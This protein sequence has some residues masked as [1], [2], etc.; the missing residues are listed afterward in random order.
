MSK[1]SDWAKKAPVFKVP[2]D[3]IGDLGIVTK[4][5]NLGLIISLSLPNGAPATQVREVIPKNAIAFARWILDT[6]EDK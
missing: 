2:D 3:N 5:G 4:N 6:F 1:A